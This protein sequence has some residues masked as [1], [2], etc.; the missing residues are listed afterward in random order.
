MTQVVTAMT[1]RKQVPDR[2]RQLKIALVHAG[3]T[4]GA[5]CESQGVTRTHL[6]FVLNG[7]RESAKLTSAV[8]AFID[9]HLPAHAA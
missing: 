8:D 1:L 4:V 6:N 9:Q 5:F 2:K 7:E 3:M